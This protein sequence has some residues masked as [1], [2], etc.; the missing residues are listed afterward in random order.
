MRRVLPIFISLSLAGAAVSTFVSCGHPEAGS[1]KP[2]R[3]T[4]S[5][6]KPG[7]ASREPGTTPEARIRGPGAFQV[8]SKTAAARK[9]SPTGRSTRR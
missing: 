6:G 2:P 9:K 5:E 3:Q 7:L 4:H 1:I 8:V